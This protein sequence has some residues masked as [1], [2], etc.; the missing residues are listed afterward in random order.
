[1]DKIF[2]TRIDE[3]VIDRIANLAKYLSTSKKQ[4]IERAIFLLAK[5]VEDEKNT[6]IFKQTSGIWK[7]EEP[8]YQT[9][10]KARKEFND[11]MQRH[12][13]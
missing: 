7:R 13:N 9:V 12:N 3:T 6:N 1:M 4:V 2:S 10:E 8:V 11:S 5:K